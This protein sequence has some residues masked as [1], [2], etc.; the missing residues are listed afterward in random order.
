MDCRGLWVPPRRG[1]LPDEAGGGARA[2][3]AGAG[4]V[5]TRR[6]PV[7]GSPAASEAQQVL[8]LGQWGSGW[9]GLSAPFCARTQC[10]PPCSLL[11]A[12]SG[13][14]RAD[15]FS[16]TDTHGQL[17]PGLLQGGRD[18][19][20]QSPRAGRVT[21]SVRLRKHCSERKTCAVPCPGHTPDSQNVTW[22]QPNIRPSPSQ[23]W[24]S[25]RRRED[26]PVEPPPRADNRIT[27]F[28]S[29]LDLIRGNVC[30]PEM[31]QTGLALLFKR[32]CPLRLAKD[33]RITINDPIHPHQ[34]PVGVRG[35]TVE[36]DKLNGRK[37]EIF[38]K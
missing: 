34:A 29:S 2:R 14:R 22:L 24:P 15:M 25:L 27:G 1:R 37:A 30:L 10:P 33:A 28:L 21:T 16:V 4:V 23:L 32:R 26:T 11:C 18:D 9:F 19:G 12:D 36:G 17:I 13:V 8:G 35:A 20:P 31:R 38:K 3:C 7:P 6:A 5:R